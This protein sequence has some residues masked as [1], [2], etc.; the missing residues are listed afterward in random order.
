LLRRNKPYFFRKPL[1]FLEVNL[2]QAN[3]L[4][5]IMK[6]EVLEIKRGYDASLDEAQNEWRVAEAG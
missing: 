2:R 6:P 5:T 1:G 3:S 4:S